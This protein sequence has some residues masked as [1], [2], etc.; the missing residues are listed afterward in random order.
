MKWSFQPFFV[1][2]LIEFHVASLRAWTSTIYPLL[3]HKPW[4]QKWA[5]SNHHQPVEQSLPAILTWAII[6]PFNGWHTAGQG[7]GQLHTMGWTPTGGAQSTRTRLACHHLRPW[8][9]ASSQHRKRQRRGSEE[10]NQTTPTTEQVPW[11]RRH[12][13]RIAWVRRRTLCSDYKYSIT[14]PGLDLWR[15]ACK[16]E[17]WCYSI[18]P[19][20][21]QLDRCHAFLYPRK[22]VLSTGFETPCIMSCLNN[23]QAWDRDDHVV[24]Q[25]LHY[26]TSVRSATRSSRLW[27]SALS[28]S[29]RHSSPST[30]HLC[31]TLIARRE[32]PSVKVSTLNSNHSASPNV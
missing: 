27:Q 15:G 16:T 19:W 9:T 28:T 31:E 1:Q 17:E 24:N 12:L 14:Q 8:W 13:R 23:K 20:V 18:H 26:D 7:E 10:R 11:N 29:K 6:I 5:A 2:L 3:C 21:W 25:F 30:E 22:G 4:A 32:K